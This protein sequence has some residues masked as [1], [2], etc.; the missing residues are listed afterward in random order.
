MSQVEMER[1]DN[2]TIRV[3]GPLVI[4][5]IQEAYEK[6]NVFLN[7][8][9]QLIFDLSEVSRSDSS[10]LSLLLQWIRRAKTQD[11]T[12]TFVHLPIK[13]Q[14]LARVSGLDK[15]LPTSFKLP[16]A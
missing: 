7:G 10:A 3:R 13:M 14:D 4:H 5:T 2:Q 6:G 8:V 1:L 15:V 9:Q 12:L 11:V 16:Q